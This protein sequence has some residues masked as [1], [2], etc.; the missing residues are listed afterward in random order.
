MR[1]ANEESPDVTFAKLAELLKDQPDLLE[2]LHAIFYGH[3]KAVPGEDGTDTGVERLGQ[4]GI[5]GEV[6]KRAE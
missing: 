1:W 4:P 5:G 2:H 6:P 3:N